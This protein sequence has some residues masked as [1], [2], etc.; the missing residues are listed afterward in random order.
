[1]I[2]PWFSELVFPSYLS[3]GDTQK[4]KLLYLLQNKHQLQSASFCFQ[5]VLSLSLLKGFSAGVMLRWHR[6]YPSQH[7][8]GQQHRCYFNH[9][10][11][12]TFT[13]IHRTW[14]GVYLCRY[15]WIEPQWPRFLKV[16]PPKTRSFAIK[17]RVVCVLGIYIYTHI[18]ILEYLCVF[19]YMLLP[20]QTSYISCA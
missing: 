9:F 2:H 5:L 18:Y 4:Y 20:L 1:M 16:N 15:F 8:K 10:P 17:T 7:R 14:I 19:V 11:G 12:V 3:I 6:L 13:I